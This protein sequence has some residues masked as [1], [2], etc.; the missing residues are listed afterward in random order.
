MSTPTQKQAE[1]QMKVMALEVAANWKR[2]DDGLEMHDHA[3]WV[4]DWLMDS[5]ETAV[6]PPSSPLKIVN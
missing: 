5:V 1:L 3:Q 4:Y 2:D 6:A